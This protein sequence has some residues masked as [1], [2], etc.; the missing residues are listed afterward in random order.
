M[1]FVPVLNNAAVMDLIRSFGIDPTNCGDSTINAEFRFPI[2]G[3]AEIQLHVR[4]FMTE[5]QIRLLQK[6]VEQWPVHVIADVF[7]LENPNGPLTRLEYMK[8]PKEGPSD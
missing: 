3:V 7:N 2:V 1:D 5:D 6:T 8:P 4:M